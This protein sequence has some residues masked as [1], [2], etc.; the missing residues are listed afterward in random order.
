MRPLRMAKMLL[1]LAILSLGSAS[2][3]YRLKYEYILP[4]PYEHIIAFTRA[5]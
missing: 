2:V 1:H 5:C 3:L 4:H